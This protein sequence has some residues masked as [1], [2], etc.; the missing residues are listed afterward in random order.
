MG[1]KSLFDI[2]FDSKIATF[3]A[4]HGV[5][6]EGSSQVGFRCVVATSARWSLNKCPSVFQG[7][8]IDFQYFTSYFVQY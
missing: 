4:T 2:L 5:F 3:A 6:T 8:G 7:N 1:R